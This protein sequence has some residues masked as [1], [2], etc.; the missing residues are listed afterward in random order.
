MRLGGMSDIVDQLSRGALRL[1]PSSSGPTQIYI[2]VSESH[3]EK[4]VSEFVLGP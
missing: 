4:Y 1:L 2:H 3:I